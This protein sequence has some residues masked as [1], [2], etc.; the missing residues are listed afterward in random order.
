V[1]YFNQRYAELSSDLSS[2]LYEIK[3]G[4]TANDSELSGMWTA[5][6]DARSYV[7]LGDPAVRLP[8]AER[9]DA[10]V[11]RTVLCIN[12]PRPSP[13]NSAPVAAQRSVQTP[14]A[15][16]PTSA[17][18]LEFGL[19]GD[20]IGGLRSTVQQLASRLIKTLASAVDDVANVEVSTYA[21]DRMDAVT[22]EQGKLTGA[23]LRA[24]TRISLTGD[25]VACV[26]EENGAV[27]QKFW[28]MH[29]DLVQ[30][31]QTHRTEMLRTAVAAAGS[32]L[33]LVK[34]G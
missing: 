20:A 12:T 15:A 11:K 8:V 29:L 30:Q 28:A 17:A 25:I 7:I 21:S 4:R 14:T 31:A 23:K 6:N 16:A 5:N 24:Y 2:E 33:N 26:P 18:D 22:Q 13:P 9:P 34:V 1:E 19:I 27:D 32:L 3:M 10:K